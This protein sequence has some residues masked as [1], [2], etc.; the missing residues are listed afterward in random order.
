MV[1]MAA[2]HFLFDVNHFGFM[3]PRQAFFHDPFWTAQRSVI[4]GTFLFTAGVSLAITMARGQTWPGFMRRWLQVV[5][6]AALVSLA[7]WVVF[8]KAWVWFGVLHGMAVMLLLTRLLAPMGKTLAL[9]GAVML[10]VLPFFKTT[11]ME[12]TV[13]RWLGMGISKPITQ[14]W[15]PLVPWM[16]VMLLGFVVG[17]W[18]HAHQRQ[19]LSKPMPKSLSPLVI[20]GRWALLFYMLH[21]PV[22]FGAVFLFSTLLRP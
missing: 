5:A 8:P 3:K 6:C 15:V 9:L 14:D 22:F 20:L 10:V 12:V 16:G 1:W 19:W 7:T 17:Q 18:A 4:L 13:V 2:F 21:Q 11:G